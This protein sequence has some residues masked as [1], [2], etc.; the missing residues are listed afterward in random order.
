MAS[1]L[2]NL[3][4]EFD[5]FQFRNYTIPFWEDCGHRILSLTFRNCFFENEEI[6]K[7]ILNECINLKYLEIDALLDSYRHC[8]L[9]GI[10][11]D[12]LSL[13]IEQCDVVRR[14]LT[15]LKLRKCSFLNDFIYGKLVRIF[16]NIRELLLEY[17]YTN[18]YKRVDKRFYI[19]NIG[20]YDAKDIFSFTC[21]FDHLKS[22]ASQIKKLSLHFIGDKGLTS[23]WLNDIGMIS[24]LR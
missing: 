2:T 6:V 19:M 10:S 12:A 3:N 13:A 18:C 15:T 20:P 7:K 23:D 4:L 24:G 1:S 16:P 14:N 21:V 22:K 9:E 8:Y 5:D 11:L 17:I